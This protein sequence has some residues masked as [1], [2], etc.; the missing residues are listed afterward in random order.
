M[1][2]L[3]SLTRKPWIWSFVAA[4][5]VWLVTVLFTGGAS[6]LGLTLAAL[7]FLLCHHRR[8]RQMLVITLGGQYPFGP[9]HH[10]TRRHAGPE[11]HG[12]DQPH[13][14]PAGAIAINWPSAA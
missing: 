11:V 3:A 8:H 12:R 14:G 2:A 13:S 5:L 7:T 4:G 1:S 6:A 10:D 9:R